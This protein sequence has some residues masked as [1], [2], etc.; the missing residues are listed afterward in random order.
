MNAQKAVVVA[1]AG[2]LTLAFIPIFRGHRSFE[3]S[4]RSLWAIGILTLA[5]AIAADFVPQ[6]AVPLAVAIVLAFGIKNPDTFGSLFK[7]QAKAGS[8]QTAPQRGQRA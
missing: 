4:Y 6:I 7:S 5:L 2:M 3:K 1:G 8:G